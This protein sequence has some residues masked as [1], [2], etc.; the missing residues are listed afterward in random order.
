MKLER[1][2]K[3]DVNDNA[4]VYLNEGGGG[5]ATYSLNSTP[6]YGYL[7]SGG[8]GGIAKVGDN[9]LSSMK[10]FGGTSN[11]THSKQMQAYN[12]RPDGLLGLVF[13][14]FLKAFFRIG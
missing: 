10:D 13:A 2:V 12:K 8:A 14:Q 6:S 11:W 9:F 4:L 7:P 5:G 3:S 1:R